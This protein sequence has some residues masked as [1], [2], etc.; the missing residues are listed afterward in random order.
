MCSINF[1][2]NNVRTTAREMCRQELCSSKMQARNVLGQN[3]GR[4]SPYA[5]EGCQ[6]SDLGPASEDASV[7]NTPK[8]PRQARLFAKE[9]IWN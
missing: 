3:A 2:Q 6:E 8:R 4:T 1:R 7:T 9:R 5:C